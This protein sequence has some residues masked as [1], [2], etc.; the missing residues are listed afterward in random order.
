MVVYHTVEEIKIENGIIFLKV[1]GQPVS[2][3]L[4][5]ISPVFI[6]ASEKELSYYELSASGYG[7][8]WPLLDEDISIDGLLG[9]RHS[10]PQWKNIA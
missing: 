2:K 7:L 3:A 5:E 4:N 1:D 6:S 8:H 9:I 10:P